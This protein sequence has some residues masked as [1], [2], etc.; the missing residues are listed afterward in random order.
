MANSFLGKILFS[1]FSPWKCFRRGGLGFYMSELQGGRA[2][3]SSSVRAVLFGNEKSPEICLA[4]IPVGKAVTYGQELIKG[5]VFQ[6]LVQYPCK[7]GIMRGNLPE[8][9]SLHLYIYFGTQV[10]TD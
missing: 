8:A 3:T 7:S 5:F 4:F 1:N 6:Q 10:Q 2:N 9:C